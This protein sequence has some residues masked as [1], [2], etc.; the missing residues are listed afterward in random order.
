MLDLLVIIC[1]KKLFETEKN[2]E[3]I[4]FDSVNDYYDISLKE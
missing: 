3:I 1:A 4:G 2:I